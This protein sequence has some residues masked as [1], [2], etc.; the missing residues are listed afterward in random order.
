MYMHVG[1]GDEISAFNLLRAPLHSFWP[2]PA[3]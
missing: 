1:F 2:L 3:L